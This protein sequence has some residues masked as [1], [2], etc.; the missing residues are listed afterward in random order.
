MAAARLGYLIGPAWL[1]EQLEKVVLPYHLD[2][3]KQIAGRLALDY[4]SE[5]DARV[6]ALVEERGRLTARLEELPIDVWPSGANF[7]LVRA[8][9]VGGDALWQALLD[10]SVL[11]R[12]CAS[13]PRLDDCLRIT[14]GTPE[15]DDALLTALEEI[16]D[17]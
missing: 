11:V 14:V 4:R 8:K 16:L 10:R 5:M 17:S 9:T 7:L 13:W 3:V 12:N 6:A 2:V 15:E 1:V